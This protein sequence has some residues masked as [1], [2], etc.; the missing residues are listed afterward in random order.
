VSDMRLSFRGALAVA[1]LPV[2]LSAQVAPSSAAAWSRH[3]ARSNAA[4]A[5]LNRAD[6]EIPAALADTTELKFSEFYGPIGDRG[7]AFSEKTR[8]LAGKRVR[9]SGFMVREPSPATGAFRFASLPITVENNGLCFAD[10]VPPA[11]AHI[12]AP[13][14]KP[15]PWRPGRLTLSGTLELGPRLEADGRNSF[16][17]VV[18]DDAS[19]A[20]LVPAAAAVSEAAKT[21]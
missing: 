13:P 5:D 6:A 7:L 3:V 10:D 14:G 17:R 12:I 19:L 16:V 20:Y 4:I 21:P 15:M 1:L 8:S 18:L 11:V 9:L 2:A